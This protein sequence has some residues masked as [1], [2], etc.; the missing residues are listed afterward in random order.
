MSVKTEEATV[1]RQVVP[2]NILI[3][4]DE[5]SKAFRRPLARH[6]QNHSLP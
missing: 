1:R 6:R 3:V 4:D 2:M 5:Q